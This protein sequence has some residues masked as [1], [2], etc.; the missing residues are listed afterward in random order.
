[1]RVGVIILVVAACAPGESYGQAD[2]FWLRS[3]NEAQE[4]RP[5][6]MTSSGRIAEESEPGTAFIIIGQVF[7]PNGSRVDGVVG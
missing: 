2:P 6:T 4:S 3:W 5:L 7:Q 1:M